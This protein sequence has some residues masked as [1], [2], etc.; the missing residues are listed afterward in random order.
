MLDLFLLQYYKTELRWIIFDITNSLT[1]YQSNTHSRRR[2]LKLNPPSLRHVRRESN[3]TDYSPFRN[4][5]VT[6]DL[7]VRSGRAV[8]I[9][10]T[11]LQEPGFHGEEEAGTCNNKWQTSA[12]LV[13]DTNALVFT[14][15]GRTDTRLRRRQREDGSGI[16]GVCMPNN[17]K[18]LHRESNRE[19]TD[20]WFVLHTHD[21]NTHSQ[22]LALQK[23]HR[24]GMIHDLW[25]HGGATNTPDTLHTC[26]TREAGNRRDPVMRVIYTVKHAVHTVSAY[27]PSEGI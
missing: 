17:L 21:A 19:T 27:S 10:L 24:T 11:L 3:Q 20:G 25:S 2:L 13:S 5:S 14:S 16:G 18:P 22:A 6:S 26:V 15:D 4:A 23:I 9:T 8:T 12:M 1:A 7:G